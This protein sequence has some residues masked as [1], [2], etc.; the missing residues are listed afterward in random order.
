M[1]PTNVLIERSEEE[2]ENTTK[3][4]VSPGNAQG[5]ATAKSKAPGTHIRSFS[6]INTYS[7]FLTDFKS[8]CIK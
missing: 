3:T 8:N 2:T 1:K 6:N 4:T 7:P 5:Q